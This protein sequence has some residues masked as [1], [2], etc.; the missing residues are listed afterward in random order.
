[1]NAS[2]MGSDYREWKRPE[3]GVVEINMAAAAADPIRG[4]M[5]ESVN[6]QSGRVL[7]G[8]NGN[9]FGS[10]RVYLRSSGGRNGILRY[11]CL[12]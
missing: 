9:V 2:R 1:M 7:V 3:N 8:W 4:G 6:I 5:R 12:R 10:D 11:M